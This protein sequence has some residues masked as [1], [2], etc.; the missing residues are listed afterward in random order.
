M[1]LISEYR[2]SI[3]LD[4][5]AN[6]GQYAAHLREIGYSGRIVSFEPLRDEYAALDIR[7]SSDEKWHTHNYAL[8]DTDGQQE[9]NVAENS[10]SSS[11]L[12]VLPR[13]LDSAPAAQAVSTQR[14]E[15]HKLDSIYDNVCSSDDI[16]YLKLDA[17]GYEMKILNGA[18][19]TLDKI[20]TIQL[21]M[22]LTPLYQGETG[23][24]EMATWLYD[25]GFVLVSLEPGHAD[26]RTGQLM[27]VD[28][29]FHRFRD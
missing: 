6:T 15:L 13:H 18:A 10:H 16:P 26:S 5:G 7:A 2:I 25:Q 27:Q 17:Q 3:I 29:I 12:A 9:I 8:G 19:Q 22:S 4:V 14:I 28:G 23:L 20:D 11:L 1:S 24:P 21:E